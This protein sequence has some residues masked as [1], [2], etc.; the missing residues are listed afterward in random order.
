MRALNISIVGATGVVGAELTRLL[1]VSPIP[2]NRLRLLASR[3]SAGRQVKFRDEICFV[4]ALDDIGDL[5][6]DSA[7]LCAGSAVSLEWGPRFAAQG[8]LV[9]DNSNAFRMDPDVPLVVPQINPSALSDRPRPGIVANPNC[10]TIQLVRV[11]RPL[12]TALD[13]DQIIVTTYQA[14]SGGGRRGIDELRNGTKAVL[15]GGSGPPA[16]RFPVSLAFN[17]VPQVASSIW[18]G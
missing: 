12:V 6:T 10:S 18:R 11:L 8:A 7:F 3:N 15:E 14:A 2:V 13:V 9:I 1:E 4:E 5:E 17:V 16:E